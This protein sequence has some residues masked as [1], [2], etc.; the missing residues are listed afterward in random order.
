ML[1]HL[2]LSLHNV[3]ACVLLGVCHNQGNCLLS[4]ESSVQEEVRK[5]TFMQDHTFG[6]VASQR[7]QHSWARTFF[8]L[9]ATYSWFIEY[10]EETYPYLLVFEQDI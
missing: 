6:R 5:H 3:L 9:K 7:E 10:V 4:S 8:S 1:V 2:F